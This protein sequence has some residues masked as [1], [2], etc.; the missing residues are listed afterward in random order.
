MHPV[1]LDTLKNVVIEFKAKGKPHQ[2]AVHHIVRRS[3]G[4]HYRRMIAP[5]LQT[6]DFQCNN[7]QQ[8]IIAA[9]NYLKAHREQRNLY[10]S[11]NTDIL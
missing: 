8:P 7:P 10:F 3:Y 1:G 6:L 5:L 9:L 11:D 2:E 4:H